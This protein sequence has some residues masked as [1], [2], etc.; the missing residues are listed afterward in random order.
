MFRRIISQAD[1]KEKVPCATAL[2]Y[3]LRLTLKKTK[4]RMLNKAPFEQRA[5]T[6]S[7]LFSSE[8]NVYQ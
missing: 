1:W 5:S 6:F 3:P 2:A 8:Y 4:I 7:K